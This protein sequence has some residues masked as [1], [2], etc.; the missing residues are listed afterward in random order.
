M[1]KIILFISFFLFNIFMLGQEKIYTSQEVDSLPRF[2]G[3]YILYLSQ[4]IEI[5]PKTDSIDYYNMCGSGYTLLKFIVNKEGKVSNIEINPCPDAI[6]KCSNLEE[7]FL[8]SEWY[9]AI[10][11]GEK[12]NSYYITKIYDLFMEY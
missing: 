8:K 6:K 1:K 7:V 12:V 4:N 9:P 5:K 10:K 3:N 2:K 11:N